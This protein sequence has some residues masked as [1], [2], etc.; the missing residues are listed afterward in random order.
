MRNDLDK[1][2]EEEF[3]E[4]N[5]KHQ[6]FVREYLEDILYGFIAHYIAK[7]IECNSIFDDD[8]KR[9]TN[10][11]TESF[12]SYPFRNKIDKERIK[13]ILEDEYSIRIIKEKPLKIEKISWFLEKKWY[14][15]NH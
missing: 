4:I 2:S 14:Y 12:N 8:F 10:T 3:L 13:K 9:I 5:Q 11:S 1:I 6:E 15:K 7:G